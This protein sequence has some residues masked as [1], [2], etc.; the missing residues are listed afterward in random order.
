MGEWVDSG[1]VDVAGFRAF[2]QGLTPLVSLDP[3]EPETFRARV[4]YARL[5]GITVLDLEPGPMR[6]TRTAASLVKDPGTSTKIILMVEGS[7]TIEQDGRTAH[8][9]R[10]DFALEDT[11]RPYSADF[12]GPTH[13][14]VIMFPTDYM[15]MPPSQWAHVTA[16]RFEPGHGLGSVLNPLIAELGASLVEL[17]PPHARRFVHSTVDLLVTMV[18]TRLQEVTEA[19]GRSTADRI[20][21][22]VEDHLEDPD[23]GPATIARA[24]HMSVRSLHAAFAAEDA[25]LAAWIRERRLDLIRR[26][27]ADPLQADLPIS[28]IASRRGITNAAYLSRSFKSHFGISPTSYRREQFAS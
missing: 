27:L 21:A 20:R 6:V 11:S 4:R 8:L 12:P 24:H 1:D 14:R 26:D 25:T 17:D 16:M 13:Q 10:G 5:D 9:D 2:M 23:L 15:G 18:S 7:G 19:A 3:V 22:W 28:A